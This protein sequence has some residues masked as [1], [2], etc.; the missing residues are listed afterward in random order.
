MVNK[1][2]LE[3]ALIKRY[4][5]RSTGRAG[6]SLETTIPKEVFDR[7]IRKRG[8]SFD[9]GLKS[10]KAVWI[11]GPNGLILTFEEAQT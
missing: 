7:E 11:Y 9:T 4:K 6:S 2:E 8:I 3:N 10:L 5:I 1:H